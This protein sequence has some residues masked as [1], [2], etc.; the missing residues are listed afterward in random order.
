M[1]ALIKKEIFSM[2]RIERNCPK[3]FHF[4]VP[5]GASCSLLIS[6]AWSMISHG[7]LS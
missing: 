7:Q 4:D 1:N 6:E 2:G 5:H 3:G